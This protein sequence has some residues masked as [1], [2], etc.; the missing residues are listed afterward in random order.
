MK[1]ENDL[2]GSVSINDMLLL[3]SDNNRPSVLLIFSFTFRSFSLAAILI[4][5]YFVVALP[6]S[7][8]PLILFFYSSLSPYL[9]FGL[10]F[11][12]NILDYPHLNICISH[13][14]S[15]IF[16]FDYSFFFLQFS[17]FYSSSLSLE[18]SLSLLSFLFWFTYLSPF[19]L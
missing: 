15:I 4:A 7:S 3:T 14:Y 16:L 18:V 10:P 8:L 6:R 5:I 9:S 11:L 13:L 17:F 12:F 2:V 19:N 1:G